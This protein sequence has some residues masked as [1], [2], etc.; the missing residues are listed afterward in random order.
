MKHLF[1]TDIAKA[2]GFPAAVIYE[3]V[4]HWVKVNKANGTNL[5]EGRHW[6]FNSVKAYGEIFDYLTPWQI[7]AALDTLVD[8]GLLLKGRFNQKGYDR[9]AW[10]TTADD[11]SKCENEPENIHL[12]SSANG[13][14]A[15]HN[16]N[17]GEPQAHLR[18]ITNGLD[19]NRKPIP[20]IK[21]NINQIENTHTARADVSALDEPLALYAKHCFK[22]DRIANDALLIMACRKHG[23][24]VV[25]DALRQCAA[26]A[27]E[28]GHEKRHT[29][30]LSRLL[31]DS[32]KLLKRA[33]LYKPD[34]SE[35]E[36]TEFDF[37]TAPSELRIWE[38]HL[39]PVGRFS[40][41][42]YFSPKSDLSPS[43][44]EEQFK[45]AGVS[46]KIVKRSEVG[47]YA[48]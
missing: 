47:S 12:M 42:W 9:T 16:S 4:C 28:P 13:F 15:E 6:T 31:N 14:D 37:S 24:A 38:Q 27:Q 18:Y 46:V 44:V 3:N 19:E 17:C 39:E 22:F 26:E 36:E 20:D 5:H 40:G 30:T 35:S 34:T 11:S 29:P 8:A 32:D 43:F 45:K 33:A 41:T 1:D 23:A 7:R 10:Y 48:G 21:P 2:H 25:G